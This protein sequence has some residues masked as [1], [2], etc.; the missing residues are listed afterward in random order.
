M[1]WIT[2]LKG[3]VISLEVNYG[4]PPVSQIQSLK[5]R[6]VTELATGKASIQPWSVCHLAVFLPS[7]DSRTDE[8]QAGF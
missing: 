3:D 7:L 6:E 4:S 8:E 2:V 5:L 1:R